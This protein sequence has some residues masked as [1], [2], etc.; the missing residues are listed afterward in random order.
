MAIVFVSPKERQHMLILVAIT[1]FVLLVTSISLGVFLAKPKKIT[2]PTTFVEPQI[3]INMDILTGGNIDKL[4]LLPELEKQFSYTARTKKG[5]LQVGKISS[6]SEEEAKSD[7]E[8]M[9]LVSIILT[10]IKTG[11]EN[12]FTPFYEVNPGKKTTK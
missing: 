11:R 8:K 10:E 2:R 3:K 7:L 5:K 4:V 6:P 12:P 1:F 9:D